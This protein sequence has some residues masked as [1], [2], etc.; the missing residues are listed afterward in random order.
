M[1]SNNSANERAGCN[2]DAASAEAPPSRLIKVLSKLYP[3]LLMRE[4]KHNEDAS[5]RVPRQSGLGRELLRRGAVPFDRSIR[6]ARRGKFLERLLRQPYSRA[7]LAD[8][9]G[10][11]GFS[12]AKRWR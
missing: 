1:G 2:A 5:E 4:Q 7:S 10:G 12:S 6:M 9:G 3:S 8:T 11:A